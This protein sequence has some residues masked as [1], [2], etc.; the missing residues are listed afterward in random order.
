MNKILDLIYSDL[1]RY[2]GKVT[3]KHL[4]WNYCFNAGFRYMFWQ[5][6]AHKT[7]EISKIYYI[8]PWLKL[9]KYKY[10]Y[11]FDIPAEVKIGKGFY[12][13]HS[14]GVVIS[15]K[16][17]IGNNCNI[18]HGITIGNNPRGKRK[19]FPI[20]GDNVYIG[21]GAIIIGNVRIG[22]NVAIGANAVVIDDIPDNAVVVGIPG[23][24]KSFGTSNQYILNQVK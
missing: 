5:R 23:K 3:L 1:Y 22:N 4:C 13:G 14:G 6:L 16:A 10:K 17:I 11:G 18:S 8:I 24:V 15:S 12:I 21:P 19:G 7:R 9:N 2:T 20:I